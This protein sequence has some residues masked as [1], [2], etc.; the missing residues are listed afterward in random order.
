[1]C[2]SENLLS[3]RFGEKAR[4]VEPGPLRLGP[5]VRK[6]SFLSDYLSFLRQQSRRLLRTVTPAL[7]LLAV[8]S[9]AFLLPLPA[10]PPQLLDLLA[11]FVH[12]L[13]QAVTLQLFNL[14]S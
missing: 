7:A 9:G 2:T 14:P 8:A 13:F 3:A 11:Q 1:M 5:R 10:T 4:E 12:L 6:G